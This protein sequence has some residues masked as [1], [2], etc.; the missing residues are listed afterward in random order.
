MKRM[1]Q[2]ACLLCL[3]MFGNAWAGEKTSY[4]NWTAELSGSSN[5]AYTIADANTS[6]GAFC[7]NGQCLFYLHQGLNCS[8]GA[9]YPV[10]MNSPSISMSLTMECTL[11]NGNLFQILTPFN[12]VFQAIQ[13]GEDI[14]FAVSL[15]SGAFAVTRFSLLGAKPA[16]E[17]VLSEAAKAKKQEQKPAPAPQ[18]LI[19]PPIQ[20]VPQAPQNQSP[21]PGQNIPSKPNS[22]DIS[23]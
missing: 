19:I 10:L 12:S 23:T 3:A 11:I 22:K 9:K 15:Q 7:S 13:S 17:R 18:I 4:Q 5:E 8:P 2:I 16:I 21:K 1:I 14:G 20:I 6:F